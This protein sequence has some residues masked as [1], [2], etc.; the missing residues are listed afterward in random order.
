[1]AVLNEIEQDKWSAQV[2][3][4][5]KILIDNQGGI[6]ISEDDSFYKLK[7]QKVREVLADISGLLRSVNSFA[8]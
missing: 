5:K 4:C 6:I 2:N 7:Y 1:M 3:Q 8:V